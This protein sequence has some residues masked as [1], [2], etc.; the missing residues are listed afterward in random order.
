MLSGG[1][2]YFF[3]DE[4]YNRVSKNSIQAVTNT[5]TESDIIEMM[6][7]HARCLYHIS[8]LNEYKN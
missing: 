6:S 4:F 7:H 3:S 2:E 8:T 5:T 1:Y